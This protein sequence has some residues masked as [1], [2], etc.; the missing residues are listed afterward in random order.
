MK[1]Y[2]GS[3]AA[4]ASIPGLV[5][6]MHDRGATQRVLHPF[7]CSRCPHTPMMFGCGSACA[8]RIGLNPDGCAAGV[9]MRWGCRSATAVP[10]E[11]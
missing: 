2:C 11:E 6:P 4:N 8:I 9:P 3:H 10:A 5:S 1:L 7:Q